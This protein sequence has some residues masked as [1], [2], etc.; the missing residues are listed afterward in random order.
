[1]N[2]HRQTGAQAKPLNGFGN[3]VERQHWPRTESPWF[4]RFQE[5]LEKISQRGQ[6]MAFVGREILGLAVDSGV[7][8][9]S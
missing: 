8:L 5:L 2:N 6:K 7:D 9:A 3:L 4:F 1:M